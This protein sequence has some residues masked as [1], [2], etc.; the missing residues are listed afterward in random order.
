MRPTQLN[1]DINED[2]DDV[3]VAWSSAA[4]AALLREPCATRSSFALFI[5]VECFARPALRA[6]ADLDRSEREKERR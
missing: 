4:L 2:D 5:L 3:D 6:R 1:D